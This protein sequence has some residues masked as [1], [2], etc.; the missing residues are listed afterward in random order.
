MTARV[1]VGLPRKRHNTLASV[2]AS[3][4]PPTE[5]ASIRPWA[6]VVVDVDMGPPVIEAEA[7]AIAALDRQEGRDVEDLAAFQPGVGLDRPAVIV[8]D[9]VAM[10]LAEGVVDLAQHGAQRP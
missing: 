8:M 10:A 6:V 9:Q 2:R 4:R 1:M 7:E 5:V 3:R